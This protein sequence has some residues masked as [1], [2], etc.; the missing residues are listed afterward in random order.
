MR[1]F[2]VRARLKLFVQKPF[3]IR[4]GNLWFGSLPSVVTSEEV[5]LLIGTSEAPSPLS[6][7]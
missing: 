6:A 3:A 4:G 5:G 2:H 7:S 1:N